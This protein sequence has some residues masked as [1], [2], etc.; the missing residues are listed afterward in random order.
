MT[1]YTLAPPPRDLRVLPRGFAARPLLAAPALQVRA[2][3]DV[4]TAVT[5]TGPDRFRRNLRTATEPSRRVLRVPQT[6][7]IGEINRKLLPA[8]VGGAYARYEAL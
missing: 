6:K 3:R 2:Q 8:Y 7:Q 5:L 4:Q 1:D